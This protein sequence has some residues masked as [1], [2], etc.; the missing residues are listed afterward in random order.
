MEQLQKFSN[1][2]S[3]TQRNDVNC[4]RACKRKLRRQIGWNKCPMRYQLRV[5]LFTLFGCFFMAFFVFLSLYAKFFYQE[6]VVDNLSTEWPKILEDRLIYSSHSVST[7]F[8]L[9]DKAM[10]D[11]IVRLSKL[12]EGASMEP[13]P[14]NSDI[15]PRVRED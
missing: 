1:T 8:Y 12:Y 15:H 13:Y 14:V 5:H 2:S 3:T 10:I 11:T 7:A 4:I 6:A 9:A